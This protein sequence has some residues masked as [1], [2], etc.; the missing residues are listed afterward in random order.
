MTVKEL[1]KALANVSDDVEVYIDLGGINAIG[2]S[3]VELDGHQYA[4]FI[5]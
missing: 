1:K 3:G 4:F 2:A 5:Y